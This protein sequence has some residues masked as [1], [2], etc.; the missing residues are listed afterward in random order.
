MGIFACL[1]HGIWDI[2]P[3]PIRASGFYFEV[4]EVRLQL[5]VVREPR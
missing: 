4:L 1:L 2:W 5:V 3:P